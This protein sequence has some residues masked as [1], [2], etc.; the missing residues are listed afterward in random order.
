M[1]TI[2][3]NFTVY[4]CI[5]AVLFGQEDDEITP[6]DLRQDKPDNGLEISTSDSNEDELDK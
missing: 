2:I 5:D 4:G 6:S 3:R 1:D